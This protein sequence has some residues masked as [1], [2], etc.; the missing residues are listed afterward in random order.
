[1]K[2]VWNDTTWNEKKWVWYEKKWVW[3]DMICRWDDSASQ[4]TFPRQ[5]SACTYTHTLYVQCSTELTVQYRTERS[6]NTDTS[7]IDIITCW[8]FQDEEK[9]YLTERWKMKRRKIWKKVMRKKENKHEYKKEKTNEM[10]GEEWR[11]RTGVGVGG[12]LVRYS[13]MK[14]NGYSEWTRNQLESDTL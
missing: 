13:E 8:G 5:S 3:H 14:K 12:R 7:I 11:G 1:M 10:R 6:T 2:R 9:R 4:S